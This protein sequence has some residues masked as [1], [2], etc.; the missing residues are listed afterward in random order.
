MNKIVSVID[1]LLKYMLIFLIIAIVLA[2]LWQ[3]LSRYLLTSPSSGSEEIARFL[4]IW[5]SLL[6]AAYSYRIKLH[7][8]LD[9]VVKKMSDKQQ[10]FATMFCHFMVLLFSLLVLLVG[11]SNLVLITFNPVQISPALGFH[12]GYVYTVLP[13]T[14]FL[15]SVYALNELM[16][17]VKSKSSVQENL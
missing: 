16:L 15:M 14:G 10:Q 13:L 3:V 11:G 8:G 2:V 9:I 7:L 4:L 5:I 1:Y 12:I 17:S 6:G